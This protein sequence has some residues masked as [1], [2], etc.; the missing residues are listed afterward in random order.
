MEKN[1]NFEN[2]QKIILDLIILQA[3]ETKCFG[4]IFLQISQKVPWKLGFALAS[5]VT[6]TRF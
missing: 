4:N 6:Y 2:T 3:D 5:F 1:W